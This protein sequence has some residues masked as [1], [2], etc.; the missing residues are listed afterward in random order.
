MAFKT[1]QLDTGGAVTTGTEMAVVTDAYDLAI[2]VRCCVAINAFNQAVF[3]GTYTLAHGLITFV[4]QVVH[5]VGTH[6]GSRLYT[7]FAFRH[8]HD[9][10]IVIPVRPG[11]LTCRMAADQPQCQQ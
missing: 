6:V 2:R 10:A 3:L 11:V 1:I 8:G 7:F 4:Q 5:V 9:V